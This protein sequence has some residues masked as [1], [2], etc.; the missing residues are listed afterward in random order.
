MDYLFPGYITQIKPFH[1]DLIWY[2]RN[3]RLNIYI[4]SRP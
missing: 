3:G 4:H 1:L 2:L